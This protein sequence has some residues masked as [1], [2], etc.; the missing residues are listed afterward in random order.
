MMS[1]AGHLS[2]IDSVAIELL[3][4]VYRVSNAWCLLGL[5]GVLSPDQWCVVMGVRLSLCPHLSYW[6]SG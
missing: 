4:V 5:L 3:S 1:Q 6:G 2:C